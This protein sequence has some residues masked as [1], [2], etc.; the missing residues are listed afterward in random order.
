[1]NTLKPLI[2]EIVPHVPDFLNLQLV[3]KNPLNSEK[4]V[5]SENE[6]SKSTWVN[7]KLFSENNSN[8]N[9]NPYFINV[10]NY[11]DILASHIGLENFSFII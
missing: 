2:D 5:T 4:S 7:Q 3:G 8:I 10:D 9:E 6:K 11:D 1:L